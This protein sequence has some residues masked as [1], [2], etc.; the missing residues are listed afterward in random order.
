MFELI[1]QTSPLFGITQTLL[2]LLITDPSSW[3]TY[4]NAVGRK[5]AL[6][7]DLFLLT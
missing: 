2:N 5:G 1:T 3:I 4:E 7:I 6:S